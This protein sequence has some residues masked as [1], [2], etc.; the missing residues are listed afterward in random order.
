MS[1]SDPVKALNGRR[2]GHICDRCNR[3]LRTGAP[4]RFYATRY[5]ENGWMLRRL[6][7]KDC[8][9]REIA[10]GTPEA[11]EIVGE[12]VFWDHRLAGVRITD[13]S[14]PREVTLK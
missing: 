14:R 7:C 12:A 2:T 10:S 9:E 11:D 13:R 8:G 1:I 3:A 6:Y 4:A 5:G